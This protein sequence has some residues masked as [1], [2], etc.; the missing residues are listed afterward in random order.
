MI[1]I[2]TSE[3]AHVRLFSPFH[4]L[5]KDGMHI[6]YRRVLPKTYK[7]SHFNWKINFNS[8]SFYGWFCWYHSLL[9]YDTSSFCKLY[10]SITKTFCLLCRGWGNCVQ[11]RP[12]S[13]FTKTRCR[14][15][16]EGC[17]IFKITVNSAYWNNYGVQAYRRASGGWAT[18]EDLI[19]Q[20]SWLLPHHRVTEQGQM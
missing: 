19:V 15:N 11:E 9:G 4:F 20:S 14:Q 2:V 8:N 7:T 13:T 6:A 3:F 16:S 12:L 18:S 1:V 17:T 5:I 10:R